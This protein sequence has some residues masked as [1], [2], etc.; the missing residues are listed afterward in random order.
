VIVF[1]V[2]VEPVFVAVLIVGGD[3]HRR[4]GRHQPAQG[5]QQVDCAHHMGVPGGGGLGIT[6]AHQGLGSQ[7]QHQLQGGIGHQLTEQGG[8]ADVAEA[9]LKAPLE[10]KLVKKTEIGVRRQGK[11]GDL[12]PELEKPQGK[13][14]AL[15]AGVARGQQP[16]ASPKGRIRVSSVSRGPCRLPTAPRD[17][18]DPAGCPSAASSRGVSRPAIAPQPP[19]AAGARPPR[20]WHRS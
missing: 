16:P 1:A 4:A 14:A 15:E 9:M 3:H 7:V 10:L 8:I 18:P 11:P 19:G 12:R 2:A 17:A 6:A 20:W 13:P 5:F